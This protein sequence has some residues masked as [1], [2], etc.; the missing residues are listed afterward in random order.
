MGEKE[1]RERERGMDL[2]TCAVTGV[3]RREEGRR[4]SVVGHGVESG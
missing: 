2:Y 1:V 4:V 3:W